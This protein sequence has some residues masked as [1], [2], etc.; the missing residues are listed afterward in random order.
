M[1]NNERL[2]FDSI[3][4]LSQFK[5]FEFNIQ[6]EKVILSG[7]NGSFFN[8]EKIIVEI[9][10]SNNK[11]G[12]YISA[13]VTSNTKSFSGSMDKMILYRTL[14]EFDF[15]NRHQ[16]TGLIVELNSENRKIL[17]F[18]DLAFFVF[19]IELKKTWPDL[20]DNIDIKLLGERNEELVFSVKKGLDDENFQ[21]YF[22]SGIKLKAAIKNCRDFKIEKLVFIDV[23]TMEYESFTID[24]MEQMDLY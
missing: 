7:N 5:N 4:S 11:V 3:Y 24:E 16:F 19:N 20:K 17:N 14:L 6:N 18:P 15:L 12:N 2:I 1:E 9:F 23:V 21:K 13:N 10:K 22:E 8:K